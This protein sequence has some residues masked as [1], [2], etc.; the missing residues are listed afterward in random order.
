MKLSKLLIG[1]LSG[2]MAAG[3][4][5]LPVAVNV[6]AAQTG[7][8]RSGNN[9]KYYGKDG[10]AYTGWHWMSTKENEKPAHWSYFGKDG[11]LKTGWQ[12]MGKGT[13]NPDG[14]ADRHWSYFG[15]NGWLRTG[16]VQL[17]KGTGEP[18]GNSNRHWSYFGLNGWLR[19]GWV[20]LGRGTNEPDGNSERHWSYFGPNGWLRT[21][22]QNM[23]YGTSN[24]DGNAAFHQSYFGPNGWL[25]TNRTTQINGIS[26]ISDSR[27]WLTPSKS[28]NT[29]KDTF[30]GEAKAKNIA[31]DHAR[32][33][34]SNIWAYKCELDFERGQ[35]V[36]EI[37]FKSGRYEYD[38]N[39]NA[40]TGAIVSFDKELD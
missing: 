40:V 30:I 22:L 26:Y 5:T 7:W 37:E 17:G 4:V 29:P 28:S 15:S 8:V 10:K 34:V 11:A 16:W 9:L 23:G 13:A 32:L 38:Y 3:M 39:I 12:Q 20:Q 2:I 14:N 33:N 24:P 31:L 1:T 35:Y 25:I 27:G 6:Q 21:G 36:Y 18:D 19:T